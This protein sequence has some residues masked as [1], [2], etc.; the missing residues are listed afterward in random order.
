MPGRTLSPETDCY[1]CKDRVSP[2]GRCACDLTAGP[3]AGVLVRPHMCWP[4]DLAA[5]G[6][7]G[8]VQS[9]R[10]EG[11]DEPGLVTVG[12][13]QGIPVADVPTYKAGGP[14]G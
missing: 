13:N 9:C 6:S 14:R 11:C 12:T 2:D 7:S 1:A 3:C 5:P 8:R 4:R 10:I